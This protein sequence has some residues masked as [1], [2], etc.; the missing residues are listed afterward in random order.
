MGG[1][2][3]KKWD[4]HIVTRIPFQSNIYF[5]FCQFLQTIPGYPPY[6]CSLLT[7]LTF[8]S[9]R[10]H[11][12]RLFSRYVGQIAIE[13]LCFIVLVFTSQ[14]LR[15]MLMFV[16]FFWFGVGFEICSFTPP[17]RF[18]L[19]CPSNKLLLFLQSEVMWRGFDGAISGDPRMLLAL[20]ADLNLRL[21]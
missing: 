13:L 19:N 9:S 12:I 2:V 3:I 7:A 20:K 8:Q 18:I 6:L 15:L 5:K 11:R 16:F 1:G 21:W 10:G 14:C 17:P 4:G